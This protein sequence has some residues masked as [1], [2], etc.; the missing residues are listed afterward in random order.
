MIKRKDFE[1][2]TSEEKKV[3]LDL[4]GNYQVKVTKRKSEQA[5]VSDVPLF[6][7]PKPKELFD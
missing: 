6:A 7:P 4:V 3:F 2:M 5:R 1:K